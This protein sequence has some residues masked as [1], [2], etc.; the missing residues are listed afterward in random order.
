MQG[1]PPNWQLPSEVVSP[2]QGY[3]CARNPF[4][5]SGLTC[6]PHPQ[7]RAPLGPCDPFWGYPSK[8]SGV[9]SCQLFA[10]GRSLASA[11]QG[12]LSTAAS[13]WQHKWATVASNLHTRCGTCGCPSFIFWS[14]TV[15]TRLLPLWKQCMPIPWPYRCSAPA[16]APGIW[17]GLPG[18]QAEVYLT[19]VEIKIQIKASR[20]VWKHKIMG[21]RKT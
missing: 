15:C 9:N 20:R 19:K 12:K 8:V 13:C 17:A 16:F 1:A 18:N 10:A 6:C 4:S 14:P 2:P 3:A 7:D 5:F 21:K 11:F